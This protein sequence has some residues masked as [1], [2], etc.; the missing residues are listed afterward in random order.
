M[1]KLISV[2]VGVVKLLDEIRRERGCSYSKAIAML[3]VEKGRQDRNLTQITDYF[4][5][6]KNIMP[7]IEHELEIL[8]IMLIWL[9]KTPGKDRKKTAEDVHEDLLK[10]MN[11]IIEKARKSA[12]K[13]EK[14][15]KN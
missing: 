2:D 15:G 5:F 14:N 11:V 8:R 4:K 13:R 3:A 1:R 10:I 7:N 9:Y 6:F 12:K